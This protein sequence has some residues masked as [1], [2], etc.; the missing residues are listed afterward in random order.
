MLIGR[1]LLII[2]MLCTFIFDAITI[3]N[4]SED[5]NAP[6]KLIVIPIQ[7]IS[8]SGYQIECH[9]ACSIEY[10]LKYT[11]LNKNCTKLIRDQC[12]CCTVCLRNEN[13]ICGGRFNVF[14][15][16]EQDFFCYKSNKILN[17]PHEQTG[18]CV[19]GENLFFF[20]KKSNLFSS[21]LACLKFL[22]LSTIK[23]N[24]T[25]CE[26]TNRRVPCDKNLNFHTKNNCENQSVLQQSSFLKTSDGKRT[27]F[28]SFVYIWQ[29]KTE[30]YIS[31][32]TS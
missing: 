5:E 24:Q 28:R 29:N 27:S 6:A 20:M 31:F 22:C 1:F 16:C 11:L 18:V 19:K 10:C 25:T 7:S 26:C 12:D 14:G 21:I 4:S 23:N 32:S 17:D 8:L 2:I 30:Q 15:I 3:E 9:E 13:D